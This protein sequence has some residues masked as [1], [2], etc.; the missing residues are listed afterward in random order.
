[1]E[2]ESKIDSQQLQRLVDGELSTDEIRTMLTVADLNPEHWRDIACAFTEDQIFAKQFESLTAHIDPKPVAP[3]KPT[4]AIVRE[5]KPASQSMP[6]VKR[7]AI[8]ASLAV[9]GIVGY[10]VGSDGPMATPEGL[11]ST[12][13]IA[14]N[15][16]D[17][18]PQIART[19]PSTP[20]DLQPEYSIELLT[21]D[22]ESVDGE[23]D[24]YQYN[25]LY[26]FV[27]S[28]GEDR[29][30]TLSD[31]MPASGFTAEARQRLSQ[32]GYEINESTN[33]M[34][35]RLQDGRQFV[36]PVRSI[37]FDQGH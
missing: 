7:W 30:V 15:N 36:V 33:Y 6:L 20:V 34:S 29:K 13:M 19:A 24:L 27:E 9:A 4:N 12:D 21:P 32:S 25:D 10:M 2:N 31:F 17:S 22:G 5:T 14:K 18:E 26:Q 3:A 37:R 28:G 35:G 23:V 8:A 16:S 1:M 11:V